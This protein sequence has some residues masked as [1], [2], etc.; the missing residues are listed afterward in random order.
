MGDGDRQAATDSGPPVTVPG[1]PKVDYVIDLNTGEMSPL[2]EAIIRSL[3]ETGA[4]GQYA[5]SPDGSLLAYV[6]TGREGSP[7]IFI[8]GTAAWG[9]R[10]VDGTSVRQMTYD[11]RGAASPAWSPDG[12]RVAYVGYGSDDV[13]DLF[14]PDVASGGSTQISDG[15]RVSFQNGLQFTPDGSSILYTGGSV[16]RPVLR[17]V[18]VAGGKSKLVIGPE[19]DLTDA[20]GGS[21]S[22]DGSLVT[23]L[24]GAR[25]PVRGRAGGWP[26]PTAPNGDPSRLRVF[27]S[28]GNLVPRREPDRVLP[29]PAGRDGHHHRRHCDGRRLAR[30]RR[31]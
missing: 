13:R 25:S 7:Q 20:G 2:P 26:T 18:P 23:F 21:L 4:S 14:V 22:P 19:G 5:P 3:G 31:Q 12:T 17:T 15:I 9:S 10:H 16:N 6:G 29:R 30:R 8:G 27:K 28:C 11:P 24:G 1:M